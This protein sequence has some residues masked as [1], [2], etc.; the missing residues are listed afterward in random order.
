MTVSQEVTGPDGL[1]GYAACKRWLIEDATETERAN[2]AATFAGG[3]SGIILASEIYPSLSRL[4]GSRRSPNS[5]VVDFS[6]SPWL[7]GFRNAV[8]AELA[9]P[10]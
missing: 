2:L 7:I 3:L 4:L 9:E 6:S 1:A 5:M 8:V 10:G